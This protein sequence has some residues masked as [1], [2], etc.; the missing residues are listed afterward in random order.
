[1]ISLQQLLGK[2]DKFFDLFEASAL[3]CQ[4]SV[5]ALKALALNPEQQSSLE[6][7]TISRRQDKAIHAEINEALCTS[8]VTALEREDIMALAEAL[9]KI[10][11][12]VEKIG[13]RALLA[14]SFLQG[15]D[16]SQ[17]ATMLEKASETLLTMLKAMRRRT[18]IAEVKQHNDHLQVVEGDGDRMVLELLRVLYSGDMEGRRVTFLK[19]LFELFEQVTDRYRDAGNVIVQIVLKNS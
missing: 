13:E 12:T 4:K 15:F 3:Q 17:P 10:P 16:L 9:Y 8:V 11:K 18:G 14:P 1:M 7:F 2:E 5:Q 6:A 19:D